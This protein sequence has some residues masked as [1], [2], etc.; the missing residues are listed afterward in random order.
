MAFMATFVL[1]PRT[2]HAFADHTG[3]IAEAM[4]GYGF[5]SCRIRAV[6]RFSTLQDIEIHNYSALD[7]FD[8]SEELAASDVGNIQRFSRIRF[9]GAQQLI[10][11]R[12]REA[13]VAIRNRDWLAADV[14]LGKALHGL[15][16]FFS[17]SNYCDLSADD[18]AVALAALLNDD[19]ETGHL[20]S[21]PSGLML[22]C[23]K[24]CLPDGIFCNCYNDGFQH[25]DV[26]LDDPGKTTSP[27]DPSCTPR[28]K[29]YECARQAATGASIAFLTMLHNKLGDETWNTYTSAPT[30]LDFED[31][32]EVCVDLEQF[33][34]NRFRPAWDG[35]FKCL[36]K[37]S[38]R[39]P[40]EKLGPTGV[41]TERYVT[42][43][44]PLTYTIHF[45]NVASA[46]ARAQTVK[47]TDQLHD[48]TVDLSTFGM[49]PIYFGDKLLVPPPGLK[50]FSQDVDLRPDRDLLVRVEGGIDSTGLVTCR[51][52]SLDPASG[53]LVTDPLAGFLPPNT[54]PPQGEGGILFTVLPKRGLAT[55]TQITNQ[56]SVVF[57]NNPS[58]DT[59]TWLN[60]VD[61]AKPE[62]HVL[63]LAASQECGAFLVQWSGTDQG[64]G[65]ERFTIF[66]SEDGASFTP[67]L[68]DVT[69]TSE[70]FYGKRD[71]TYAFYS[72]AQDF[73]GNQ[74]D[75]A[76]IA[77][78]RTRVIDG[79]PPTLAAPPAMTVYS[80]PG[81][82]T[83]ALVI[84]DTTLGSAVVNDNC[85]SGVVTRAGV[86]N[87]NV[88]PVGTTT[89][90][91]TATDA[92]GNAAT[93]IQGVT[94]VDGTPPTIAAP[95]DTIQL[96]M[97]VP[98]S[99]G[100]VPPSAGDNCGTVTVTNDAPTL[101]MAGVTAVTWTVTD[102][103][104][105][106]GTATQRVRI[107]PAA[108]IQVEAALRT[109][110]TGTRPASTKTAQPLILKVFERSTVGSPDP[111]DF[112]TIWGATTGLL[113]SHNV[114]ISGPTVVTSASGQ[115]NL[116][117]IV[118]PSTD[119]VNADLAS[120]S[121]LVVGQATIEGVS[122]Y[123]GRPRDPLATGSTTR[124]YLEEIKNA[125]GRI[126]AA[127][128]TEVPGSL[129]LITEPAC[130]EFTGTQELYPIVY[131]S[132]E[133]DWSVVV[134]ADPP[135]GFVSTPGALTTDVVPDQV[136]TLQFTITDVGSHWTSTRVTHR[137][138]HNG[139]DIEVVSEAGMVNRQKRQSRPVQVASQQGPPPTRYAL[140]KNQ[141][142]PFNPSTVLEFDLP[143]PA[144]V[145]LAVYDIAGHQVAVLV[146]RRQYE[147]GRHQ[148]LFTNRGL[149]S[150][151]YYYRLKAGSFMDTKRMV[152][153]Q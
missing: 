126:A 63:P 24:T 3:M 138:R 7:H 91:Y 20:V 96:A 149:A 100:L 132:V 120:G 27:G 45:E 108:T 87:G 60:T 145:T 116:Y 33:V 94:V 153:L 88:F 49:G 84:A 47:V 78:A 119:P 53:Q 107:V 37:V 110:G 95:R 123:P 18:R 6:G 139:R 26:N 144:V 121:Y 75:K 134:K 15:Q 48:A 38:G 62:S 112:G 8:R 68:E 55:G 67:W 93:A 152:L 111:K 114:S 125:S 140:R 124:I 73:A 58:L 69:G 36:E 17:H 14:A 72:V 98:T 128:T 12:E 70:I 74:E 71:K 56:A 97:T 66:V 131:E 136:R 90:T 82:T 147:P 109:T 81:A 54:S 4:D 46:S 130:L 59:Q 50:A 61:D 86:P 10:F 106:T 31:L 148:V 85:P 79:T 30:D 11:D 105:N 146:D 113:Q 143:E 39:D 77:E 83:C 103:H 19:V 127:K 89:V 142:N 76:A 101:F 16:D 40:N 29:G 129:L 34:L 92:A 150:G 133:G 141:P 35:A 25:N 151:V 23:T 9:F 57:D 43:Q 5:S 41:G 22:G 104:G 135:E 122:V 80:G 21:P 2:S 117:T 52:S 99:L 13:V 42:G 28:R 102:S 32:H 1:I 115:A 51:F 118:V 137:L 65:V 44:V 64:A